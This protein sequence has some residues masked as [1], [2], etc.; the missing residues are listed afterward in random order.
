MGKTNG[1]DYKGFFFATELA[2]VG[3]WVTSTV[4][5]ITKADW[6]WAAMKESL[7]TGAAGPLGFNWLALVWA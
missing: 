2:W 7:N 3:P 4:Y 1:T 5:L 6:A